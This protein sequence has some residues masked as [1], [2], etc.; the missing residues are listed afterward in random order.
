M[1]WC[2]HFFLFCQQSAWNYIIKSQIGPPKDVMEIANESVYGTQ[3]RIL[4]KI[5]LRVQMNAKPGQLKIENMG[6]SANGKR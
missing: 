4:L 1:R 5:D 3:L 6:E 2:K